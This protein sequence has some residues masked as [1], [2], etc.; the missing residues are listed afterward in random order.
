MKEDGVFVVLFFVVTMLIIPSMVQAQTVQPIQLERKVVLPQKSGKT[1][2]ETLPAARKQIVEEKSLQPPL[3]KLTITSPKAGDYLVQGMVYVIEWS[4]DGFIPDNCY[5]IHLFQGPQHKL[6]IAKGICVNGYRWKIPLSLEPG[7]DYRIRVL[8][9]D[10]KVYA[11]SVSFPVMS[12]EPN[13]KIAKLTLSPSQPKQGD[14]IRLNIRIV[15]DGAAKSNAYAA[16]YVYLA[17]AAAPQVPL[18]DTEFLPDFAFGDHRDKTV[19]LGWGPNNQYKLPAG[20][21]RV[22]AVLRWSK[23]GEHKEQRE[24]LVF[25]L[26][27]KPE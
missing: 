5:E 25:T 12:A 7:A 3:G 27:A 17:P 14:D 16:L 2:S 11:N 22:V 1:A 13:L 10:K 8:T 6:N 20:S 4:K 19:T 15:N 26:A 23:G 21:V 9:T 18:Y 24:D